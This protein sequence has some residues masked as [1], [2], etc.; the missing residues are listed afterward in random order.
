MANRNDLVK[1]FMLTAQ[2]YG[3]ELSQD[4]AK[5]FLDDLSHYPP[6]AVLTALRDHRRENNF[7]PTLADITKRI[8]ATDGRPGLEEAWAM[9]PKDNYTSVVWCEEMARAYAAA[10]RLL[11]EGDHVGARMAF[12]ECYEKELKQARAN[13][14]PPKWMPLFGWEKSGRVAAVRE[15]MDRGRISAQHAAA[16][17]P[18]YSEQ[19]DRLAITGPAEQADPEEAQ[20]QIEAKARIHEIVSRIGKALP[21]DGQPEDSA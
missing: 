19:T 18:D 12:K 4:A 17:L 11:D 21:K 16:L 10:G 1:A 6:D 3:K 2:L 13:K 20:A 14:V 5:L 15:A 9:V 7:F 8:D